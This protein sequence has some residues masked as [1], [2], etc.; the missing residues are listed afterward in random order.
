MV[1]A[2]SL[3][4][5]RQ[6]R[7]VELLLAL[8]GLLDHRLLAAQCGISRPRLKDTASERFLEYC[9]ENPVVWDI[10]PG[11]TRGTE[12]RTGVSVNRGPDIIYIS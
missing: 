3:H 12:N 10:L 1:H 8:R 9:S 11:G 4:D 7:D 6:L 2:E 5:A